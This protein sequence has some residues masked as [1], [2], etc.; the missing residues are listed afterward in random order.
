[1]S[2]L[3]N[4]VEKLVE[5]LKQRDVEVRKTTFRDDNHVSIDYKTNYENGDVADLTWNISNPISG[6]YSTSDRYGNDLEDVQIL[7]EDPNC[8]SRMADAML[9]I[10]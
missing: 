6:T 5:E 7:L 4:F 9:I 3:N 8:V 2:I 1:M 10:E